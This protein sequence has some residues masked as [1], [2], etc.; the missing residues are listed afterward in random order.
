MTKLDSARD[1]ERVQGLQDYLAIF[2]RRRT[3]TFLAGGSLLILSLA[4]AFL[5]PATYKSTATILIEEQDI[6][7]D[8]VRSTITSYADQRIETIKQQVMSRT[9][10]WKVVEQYNLYADLRA[11]EPAEVVMKRFIND[12]EVSVI[13]AD[14]VNKRTNTQ[15]KA[16]IAFTVSYQ[17]VSPLLAQKVA[18]ELTSLFLVQNLK[19]REKQA[20]ETTAFL[21]QEAESLSKH[22]AEV[23][24]KIA[25]FKQKA[26]GALPELMQVN[27]Q[28]MHQSDRELTDIDQQIRSLMERK[29]YLDGEL[30]TIKPHTPILSVTG[31]RI[32]DSI[33][34]LHS[35]R[36]EYTGLSANLAP[37]HPDIMKMEKEIKALE[38]ETGQVPE[39]DEAAKQLIKAKADLA[40]AM[41]RLGP[42]H[43]DV[44]KSRLTIQ[45]LEEEVKRLGPPS[46]RKPMLR[47][48][49]PAYI[50]I[51]AQLN[52]VNSSLGAL[53]KSRAAV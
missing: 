31:E 7:T 46:P 38:K 26:D 41:K 24:D 4:A 35:L 29:N 13:S 19:S 23:D 51:Q 22:I 43:P 18:N 42:E 3:L 16:T 2:R 39:V 32:L 9:T 40:T 14:V 52:S 6:P 44:V 34:R 45:A 36:A 5:W 8:L 25:A 27:V 37:D 49:N 11:S 20:Q 28:I 50:N 12:I 17:S 30:A 53:Q 10:L 33:E 21:Q 15:M 1:S 47:P 48:E